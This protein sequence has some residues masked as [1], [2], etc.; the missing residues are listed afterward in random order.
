MAKD[1]SRLGPDDV[2]RL[3][4]VAKNGAD[5]ALD[6]GID[7]YNIL[8]AWRAPF[9]SSADAAADLNTKGGV[10]WVT[11]SHVDNWMA[12]ASGFNHLTQVAHGLD[13]GSYVA[14]DVYYFWNQ[15]TS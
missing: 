14:T 9:T 1:I 2:L 11:A 7:I 12:A 5:N 6:N 10:S 8:T 15:I 4:N 3:I 13:A